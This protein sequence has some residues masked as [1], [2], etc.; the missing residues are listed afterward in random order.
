MTP[1]TRSAR[2][3][4][5]PSGTEPVSVTTPLRTSTVMLREVIRES[6]SSEVRT[7]AKIHWSEKTSFVVRSL[8]VVA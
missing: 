7:L 2:E 1:A 5:S 8:R 6:V 4:C 3:R